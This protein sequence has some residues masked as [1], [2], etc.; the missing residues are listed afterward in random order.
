MFLALQSLWDTVPEA[1]S[2]DSEADISPTQ[3]IGASVGQETVQ[4]FH[5][6]LAEYRIR[7]KIS[8]VWSENQMKD[9]DGILKNRDKF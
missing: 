1:D 7:N 5:I 6:A 4:R 8:L 2:P 3:L 9:G